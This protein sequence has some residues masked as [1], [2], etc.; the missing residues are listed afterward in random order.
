MIRLNSSTY[1]QFA[2]L[3]PRPYWSIISMTADSKLCGPCSMFND[4]LYTVASSLHANRFSNTTQLPVFMMEMWASRSAV[5]ELA[6]M[7]KLG[8]RHLPFVAVIEPDLAPEQKLTRSPDEMLT[9]L[10]S[11]QIYP[12][13]KS[14]WDPNSIARY[15]EQ[16]TGVQITIR[17]PWYQNPKTTRFMFLGSLAMGAFIVIRLTWMAAKRW[18]RWAILA[19]VATIVMFYSMAGGTFLWVNSIPLVGMDPRTQRVAFFS[20]AGGLHM[21]MGAE[22]IIMSATCLFFAPPTTPYIS[23]SCLAMCLLMIFVQGVFTGKMGR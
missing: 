17:M 2:M 14:A 16:R 19:I 15:L 20:W 23:L 10:T 3:T 22:G 4:Q 1:L 7:Q 9:P 11:S 18:G 21:E 13:G 8:V 6:L 5:Y 12:L